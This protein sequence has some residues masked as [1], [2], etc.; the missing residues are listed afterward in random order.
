MSRRS[1]E[2]REQIE[3]EYW[4][5]SKE[6]APGPLS[7][8]NLVNKMGDAQV[9]L[10]LAQR[11]G[12]LFPRAGRILELG[13]GQGWAACMVKRLRPHAH[14]TTTDISPHALE[15]V[16]HW[17]R[18]FDVRLDHRYA[19]RSYETREPDAAVDLAFTFA[20]AHHFIEQERA[21]VELSRILKPGGA[22]LYLYEPTSNQFFYPVMHWRV[23]KKRPAV[24]ED[25][26]VP[27]RLK[28]AAVASALDMRVDFY[29]SLI[30]RG[31]IETLY[32]AMMSAAPWLCSVLPCSANIVITKPSQGVGR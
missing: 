6:E 1:V 30:K 14:V 29:P 7:I 13:G 32:Y 2:E 31:R 17:E 4:R 20:S 9:F 15:V 25:L 23:N 3:I 16:P 10:D 27:A 22:A 28:R 8:A 21:L 19:C 24:P 5:T 12:A 18:V 26:L 11:Y